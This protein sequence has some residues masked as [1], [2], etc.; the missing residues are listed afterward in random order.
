ML[1]AAI[2]GAPPDRRPR[3]RDRFACR[4]QVTQGQHIHR[5]TVEG[6][7]RPV[8]SRRGAGGR[9]GELAADHVMGRWRPPTNEGPCGLFPR[10]FG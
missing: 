7:G 6:D 9:V 2:F 8:L 10:P 4:V 3:L 5:V 1:E